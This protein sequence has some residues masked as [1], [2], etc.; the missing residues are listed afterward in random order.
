MKCTPSPTISPRSPTNAVMP[1]AFDKSRR[2]S[3]LSG[4]KKVI[5]SGIEALV[6]DV[7]YFFPGACRGGRRRGAAR[8]HGQ[9]GG[10]RCSRLF[11]NRGRRQKGNA[12]S[13]GCFWSTTRCPP[14][15]PLFRSAKRI[16][17]EEK[18]KLPGVTT[19]GVWW[20]AQRSSTDGP[21]LKA[22]YG[23]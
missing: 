15:R 23:I 9:A 1:W 12:Q 8:L 16:Q 14:I 11:E 17:T 3:G 13:S 22:G 19:I 7:R 6:I 21:P 2:F 10:G 5:E 18:E 20:W 4:Y